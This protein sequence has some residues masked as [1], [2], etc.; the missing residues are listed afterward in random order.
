VPAALSAVAR[1]SSAVV[2]SGG[3]IRPA[4]RCR[5]SVAVLLSLA[6]L[7]AELADLEAEGP[8]GQLEELGGGAEAAV[9]GPERLLDELD[10]DAPERLAQ[11]FGE[12]GERGGR[13]RGDVETLLG[14]V[15]LGDEVAL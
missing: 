7:D 1:L 3:D 11:A 2:D 10:L 5:Q 13:A 15:G 6:P 12:E 4:A 14:Q 9:G 8:L